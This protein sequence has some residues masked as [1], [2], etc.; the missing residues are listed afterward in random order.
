M[1]Y[2]VQWSSF[3]V[4]PQA[5]QPLFYVWNLI[6]HKIHYILGIN[7]RLR[8]LKYNYGLLSNSNFG[9][10]D[11]CFKMGID[12]GY[13]A[14]TYLGGSSS[15]DNMMGLNTDA[16]NDVYIFG[17]TPSTNFPVTPDALQA[18]KFW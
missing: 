4:L 15:E 5:K 6:E 8:Y 16:N 11:F 18:T 10:T 17:Y 7:N 3:L 1:L 12:Q 13:K 14:G 9:G 2:F